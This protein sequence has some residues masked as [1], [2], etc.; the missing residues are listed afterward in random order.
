MIKILEGKLTSVKKDVFSIQNV[1]L[2]KESK[3]LSLKSKIAEVKQ[4][5]N[6]LALKVSELE[7]LKSEN[8]SKSIVGGDDEK[9]TQSGEHTFLSNSDEISAVS[10]SNKNLSKYLAH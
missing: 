1:S 10:K 8:I 5:K 2:K 7:H 4:M 6:E 9:N 3:I